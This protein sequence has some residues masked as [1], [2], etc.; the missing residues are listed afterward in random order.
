MSP[1]QKQLLD[2][3]RAI[4]QRK[5]PAERDELLAKAASLEQYFEDEPRLQREAAQAEARLRGARRRLFWVKMG[6]L[7]CALGLAGAVA[8]L[9]K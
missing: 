1:E 5:D 6:L 3:L 2:N 4:A 9:F 7:A 8:W